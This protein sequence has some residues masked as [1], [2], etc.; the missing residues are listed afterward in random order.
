MYKVDCQLLIKVQ[1]MTSHVK[2]ELMFSN[3]K[4]IAIP[5]LD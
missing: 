4:L 2:I 1:R 5:F 3:L